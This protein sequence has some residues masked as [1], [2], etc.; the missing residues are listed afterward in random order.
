MINTAN[1]ANSSDSDMVP[2][3]WAELTGNFAN[4]R[5]TTRITIDPGNPNFPNGW[6]LRHYGF[7]GANYPGV[8][9]VALDGPLTMKYVMTFTGETG[10]PPAKKVLVYTRN[11]KGYV[12]ENIAASVAAI[13]K[14]G[15]ENGFLV[16]ATDDTNF[17]TDA[18]L[19]Q[20][21]TVVFAN[22]N[23]EAFTNER[24]RETF[25]RFIEAG[26]RVRGNSFSVGIGADL[27]VLLVDAGWE[28]QQPS[29]VAEVHDPCGGSN[30]SGDEGDAGGFRVGRRVLL[31]RVRESEHASAADG[32]SDEAGGSGPGEGEPDRRDVR[33]RDAALVD[34]GDGEVAAV[35]YGIG[36]Q[37]GRLFEP[38]S[39]QPYIGWDFV[40][41]GAVTAL[42]SAQRFWSLT[43]TDSRRSFLKTALVAGF[44]T[45]VPSRVFG[46]SAPSNLIRVGQIGCGRIARASEFKGLFQNSDVARYVAVCDLDSVR[47]ADGKRAIEAAY[48]TKYGSGGYANV[49]TYSNY[50]EML[51]DKSI[52]A[53]CISTPDHWHALPAIEA[54]LAGKDV[55]LQKPASL[56]IH[57]GRQMADVLKRSGRVLQIGSQQRSEFQFR[58][59]CELIR[60]GRLGKLKEIYIGLPEDPS[61][62]VEYEMPVPQNL[63]YDMWLG[64]T[65]VVFYTEKRVHP[66]VKDDL[67]KRYDRP[68]WLRCEQFG[69]G[70]ITGWGAHHIDIAHWAM[71]VEHSGPR[72]ILATA[73]FPK[74][75]LWDVHGPYHVKMTYA[76]GV[77]VYISE[78]YP[79]GL[80]FLGEDGWLWVT[81]GKVQMSDL[82]E[83]KPRNAALDASD[84]KMLRSGIGPNEI[85]LH[86]SPKNDHHLDWLTS[87]KTRQPNAS[88]AEIGHRSC[89]ACLVAHIGMKLER[90]L[91]WDP[92]VERFVNDDEANGMLARPQR[93]Q[94]G[95]DAFLEK[96]QT[97]K[98]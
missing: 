58:Y 78:K 94:Y 18:T 5:A 98:A 39:V 38:D 1:L 53:V 65:P 46:Q 86:E 66:Q 50:R 69:A 85:H 51:E 13:E 75:G 54:A 28:V 96:V 83:G 35:L 3:A 21:D 67:H 72:D 24:Q 71:N 93:A 95:T 41:F 2:N 92:S 27:A 36:A 26:A 62:P 6:C 9:P 14:M 73:E 57:E 11:G 43:M 48:A 29:E 45:I 74:K 20:Y 7:L 49:K 84:L 33:A 4:G 76:N 10:T 77:D 91:T 19:D 88:P 30:Q 59:A 17:I 34:V 52:D 68:G 56:T 90:K 81:R 22:S 40:D 97:S 82:A 64:S 31:S 61:G 12:H 15:R 42:G 23:N 70:M 60:N 80:K 47:V 87:I 8:T 25:K 44:P 55:Y 63:N 16:D 89:T 79:T 37:E 32:R